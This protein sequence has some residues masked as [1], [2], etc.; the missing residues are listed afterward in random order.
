GFEQKAIW[1]RYRTS[2]L[3]RSIIYSSVDVADHFTSR[4]PRISRYGGFAQKT[5]SKRYRFGCLS[6][7]IISSS[8]K[9]SKNQSFCM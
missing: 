4:F 7:S 2:C 3:S 5:V 9:N 8:A 1:K 6:R